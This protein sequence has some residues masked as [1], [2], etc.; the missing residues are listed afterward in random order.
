LEGDL[1]LQSGSEDLM[2]GSGSID[3]NA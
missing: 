3:L 2:S 1:M